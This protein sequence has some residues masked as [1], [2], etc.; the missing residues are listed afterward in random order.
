M[1]TQVSD[2]RPENSITLS[3]PAGR[4]RPPSATSGWP[5]CHTGSQ[6]PQPTTDGLFAPA[7]GTGRPERVSTSLAVVGSPPPPGYTR[8][9]REPS[10]EA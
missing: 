5:P 4:R 7:N 2:S 9:R 1:V 3:A 6:L 8:S 10:G